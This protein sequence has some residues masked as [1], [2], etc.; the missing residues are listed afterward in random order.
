M[1]GLFKNKKKNF[2]IERKFLLKNLP[3]YWKYKINPD[4]VYLISQYYYTDDEGKS[5][6]IRAQDDVKTEK[7][8]YIVTEKKYVKKGVCEEYEHEVTYEEFLELKKKS[9]RKIS[10]E[11]YVFKTDDGLKWEIDDYMSISMV[12]AEIE[13]P[14]LNKK[15]EIP[16]FIQDVFIKE[17][18]GESCFSNYNLAD[19]RDEDGYF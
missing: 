7:R 2:E 19:K 17:L 16:K 6:R 5:K 1:W 12:T 11:R 3:P 13:L 14:S 10:K 9:D 4:Y 8:I 15:I 18:T